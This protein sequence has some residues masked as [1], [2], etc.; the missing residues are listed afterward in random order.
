MRSVKIKRNKEDVVKFKDLLYNNCLCQL[1][2]T[3]KRRRI[4]EEEDEDDEEEEEK[5]S[6]MERDLNNC[7]ATSGVSTCHH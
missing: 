3:S 6:N 1:R 7:G 2:S 4:K 5:G